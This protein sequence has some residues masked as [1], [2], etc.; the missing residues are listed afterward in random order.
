MSLTKWEYLH[1]SIHNTK[2]HFR[3]EW[4]SRDEILNLLGGEG[5][6]LTSAHY[7]HHDE[8]ESFYFKRPA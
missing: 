2:K 8:L 3:G 1:V 7:D 4:M 6:E 5:W